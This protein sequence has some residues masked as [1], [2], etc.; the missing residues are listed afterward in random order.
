MRAAFAGGGDEAAA[1][2]AGSGIVLNNKILE[3]SHPHRAIGADFGIDR[4]VP[5]VAAGVDVHEVERLPA[6][7]FGL[8]IEEGD[9]LHRRLAD[10]GLALEALRQV[11]AVDETAARSS[12]VAAEDIHLAEVRRDGVAGFD[13]VDLLGRHAA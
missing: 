10:H 3:I 12:R 1:F 4:G 5:L 7:A 6:C 8:H 9:D 11:V 2:F 13:D